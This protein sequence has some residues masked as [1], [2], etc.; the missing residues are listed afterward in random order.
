MPSFKIKLAI[1]GVPL[2]HTTLLLRIISRS[3]R[4]IWTGTWTKNSMWKV[5]L[6]WAKLVSQS[7]SKIIP[8]LASRQLSHSCLKLFLALHLV[9]A[10]K[11]ITKDTL[12][13]F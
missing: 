3:E 11:I 6:Y 9:Y 1:L 13:T 5:V 12:T 10:M 7:H 2:C 8:V 4:R